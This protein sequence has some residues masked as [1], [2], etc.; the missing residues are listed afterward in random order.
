[1]RE[2]RV[3]LADDH[4]LFRLGL[5]ELL[6]SHQGLNVVGEAGNGL[7]AISLARE[8]HPDVILMDISMSE[9]N[10]I[11][12]CRRI[13]SEEPDIRVVML[14][15]H[16]DR[17]YVIESLR[18]GARGYVLK[19]AAPEELVRAIRRVTQ[20]QYYLSESTNQQIIAE[21]L[22]LAAPPATG[23]YDLLSGRERTVLQLIA[24]GNTTKQIAD[25]LSLSVKTVE[26]HRQHI[27]EKL[28]LFTV[29]DLTRYAIREGLTSL[30]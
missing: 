24:E 28:N 20:N 23:V 18:A 6:T 26:T 15:M 11:E 30:E 14:S 27:M 29:A 5:R 4:K 16:A 3:I 21:F 9:L 13:V 17:R 12:A 1:M 2:L 7:E 8:L 25:K 19:D 10:G 22:K